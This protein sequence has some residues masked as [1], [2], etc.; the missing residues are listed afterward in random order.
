MLGGLGLAAAPVAHAQTATRRYFV[1]F[2]DKQGTPYTVGQPQAFLSAR[3][4]ARRSKQGIAVQAR[5][6]PVSPSYVTQV[7]GVAGARVL[8]TSRWLNGAVVAADSATMVSVQQLN[9]VKSAQLLSLVGP[10]TPAPAPAVVPTPTPPTPTTDRAVYGKAYAQAQLMGAVAM[11]KAGYR[12]EGMQIA[13][14]DA[15]FPGADGITALQPIQQQGRLLSTRNFVDGGRSVY[16]RNGHGTACLST[17]GAELPGYFVGT[18]PHAAFHLL[19][20]ED[21]GSENPIEEANWLAAAEYADSAGVDVISSSLGYTTFDVPALSHKYADLNG[22]T[23]IG[24]RAALGAARVG[25]VVVNA[26][27]NDGS[28]AWHYIGVP[29]DADSIISTGAVDSLRAHAYFSSYGPTADGR[30]K[31]TLSVM[32]VASGVLTPVGAAVRGNGTSYATPELAGLVAG[33]WQA[34]PTLTAQQVIAALKS[35]ASQA[36]APDNTLGWGIPDFVAAYNQQHPS[37]PLAALDDA[38]LAEALSIYPNPSHSD[39]LTLALPPA[40]RGQSLQIRVLDARGVVVSKQTL[41]ASAA[42]SLLVRR[43]PQRLAPGTYVCV[44]KPASGP[45]RSVRFVQE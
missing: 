34:N 30:I 21:V 6:L 4:L 44:V 42:T 12:G 17:I 43:L 27:G 18:A 25:M 16:L 11:Q 7:S 20:T 28:A 39:E 36:A 45:S 15:G 37:A 32:G 9:G 33:F 29:A 31:P 3:A 13:I 22:R 40:L 2:N 10:K 8:Y 5:D 1:Y 26:A 24:S 19:I 35:T 14:F 23:A 38:P 41:T